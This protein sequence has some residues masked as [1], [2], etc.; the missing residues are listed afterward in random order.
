MTLGNFNMDPGT[1]DNHFFFINFP[2]DKD[3]DFKETDRTTIMNKVVSFL[4]LTPVQ[5]P[6][7]LRYWTKIPVHDTR[8]GRD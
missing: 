4:D 6:E 5:S 7:S 8:E 2:D 1:Y 3:T